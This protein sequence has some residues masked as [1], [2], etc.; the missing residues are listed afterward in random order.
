ML[1][2]AMGESDRGVS[3]WV[4]LQGY[5]WFIWGLTQAITGLARQRL[6]R[7]LEGFYAVKYVDIRSDCNLMLVLTDK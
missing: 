3:A 5:D 2:S 1:A 7:P 4:A 6:I